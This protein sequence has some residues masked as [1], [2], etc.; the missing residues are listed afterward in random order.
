VTLLVGRRT[1]DTAREAFLDFYTRTDGTL[2]EL[3][4]IDEY[5][6]YFSVIVS[7]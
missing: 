5:A 1:T 6:A 3:I 2:P 7:V 4:T